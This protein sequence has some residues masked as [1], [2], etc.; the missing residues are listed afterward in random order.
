MSQGV[1]TIEDRLRLFELAVEWLQVSWIWCWYH[2]NL[3]PWPGALDCFAK[4]IA[5]LCGAVGPSFSA[6]YL[7]GALKARYDVVYQDALL[8]GVDSDVA[9]AKAWTAVLRKVLEQSFA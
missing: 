5:M 6:D 8:N 3:L 7:S 9:G 4:P 1:N 2:G